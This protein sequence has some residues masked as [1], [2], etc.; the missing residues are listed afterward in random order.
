LCFQM[1][2]RVHFSISVINIIGILLGIV[3]NMKIAYGSIAIIC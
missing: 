3:L 2:F 1:N